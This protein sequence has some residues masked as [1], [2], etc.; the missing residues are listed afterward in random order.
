MEGYK[1]SR[2]DR[3]H[4]GGGGVCVYTRNNLKAKV[5]KD[6]S[7]IFERNFHQLWISLQWKKTK[8]IVVCTTYQP[9]DC[10]VSAFED[11]LKPTYMQALTLNKPIVILGDLNC[12][13]RKA[14]AESRALNN[15]SSEMNLQQL[16]KHPTRITA[17]TKSLLNVIL[18][19]CPQSVHG[20]GVINYSISD[21]LPI[22]VELKVKAPKPSPH[23]IT[24]RSYKNYEPSALTADLANQSD[25]LLSI[26]S[27]GNVDTKLNTLND[28]VGSTLDLH[29][30][31]RTTRIRH[32]PSPFVSRGIKQLMKTRDLLHRNFFQSRDPS[33][34]SKYK[35]SRD[36][37]KEILRETERNYTFLE[38][39]QSKSNPSSLWKVINRVIPS[40]NKELQRV[41]TKD[42]KTVADEFNVFFTSVGKTAAL[43]ASHLAEINNIT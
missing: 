1:L 43:A 23:Y 8:S 22:F 39:Q 11:T 14:C 30:P 41:Y 17:T 33:D 42:L 13:I 20:S 16:I 31:V 24:A 38:V 35:E 6:L 10:P 21:H 4:M 29:A 36:T 9:D 37:I 34:W 28:V 18:V 25:Q 2:L 12:D 40:K 3:L 5:L 7:S 19:S 26:F 27:C 32:R 15:F